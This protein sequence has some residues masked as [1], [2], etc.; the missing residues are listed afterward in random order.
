VGVDHGALSPREP[1]YGIAA[2]YGDTVVLIEHLDDAEDIAHVNELAPCVQSSSIAHRGLVE[3]VEP[4]EGGLERPCLR[5]ASRPPVHVGQF[6]AQGIQRA[7][8]D[9]LAEPREEPLHVSG[10]IAVDGL[11]CG[12]ARDIEEALSL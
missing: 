4:R 12:A 3:L 11:E 6:C 8:S 9:R 7:M 2:R 10:G 1:P 5:C